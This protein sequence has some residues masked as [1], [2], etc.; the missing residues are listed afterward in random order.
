MFPA[1][2]AHVYL[3]VQDFLIFL[4]RLCQK[5]MNENKNP[6][7]LKINIV[8]NSRKHRLILML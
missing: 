5:R 3:S 7:V 6:I 1:I 2:S 4:Q 8:R